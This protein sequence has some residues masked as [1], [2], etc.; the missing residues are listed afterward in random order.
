MYGKLLLLFK[1]SSIQKK[2]GYMLHKKLFV[3]AILVSLIW[4]VNASAEIKYG[5][6][7]I[8]TKMEI[9]GMP[10][11]M[12]PMSMRQCTTKNDAV[13]KS[14]TKGSECKTKDHKVSGDT[15]TYTIECTGQNSVT[16]TS[17]KMIYKENTFD[18][19]STTTTKTTGQ[20][21]RQMTT[22]MSGKY[23]GPC[24]K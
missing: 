2:E 23:L 8:T 10:A 24:D 5:L 7:E 3:L 11:Q 1:I 4:I 9:K 16:L 20:P 15:V 19:T 13:P 21:E 6:W 14:A 22:K 17:G 18:G 12:P